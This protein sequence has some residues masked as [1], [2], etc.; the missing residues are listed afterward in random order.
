MP[1]SRPARIG[2]QIRVEISGMLSRQVHDPG[3]GFLTVTRVDVT[4]DLQHARVYYTTLG[5][6]KARR[7][8]ARALERAS[9]FLRR[10]LAGRLRLRR[11][12]ELQ[13]LF[14][15]T[16]EQHDRIEKILLDLQEERATRPPED[17]QPAASPPGELPSTRPGQ[18][19]RNDDRE[20]PD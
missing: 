3:I 15:A 6:D 9:P 17:D 11:A 12:P 1:N 14:D 5:D 19:A 13:F 4:A 8:S 16:V 10:Q 7:E 2:D 18:D 20:D